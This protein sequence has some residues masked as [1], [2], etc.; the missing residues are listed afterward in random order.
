M[1]VLILSVLIKVAQVILLKY[2][3]NT[4]CSAFAQ[5][6]ALTPYFTMTYRELIQPSIPLFFPLGI[7]MSY[8]THI[9]SSCFKHTRIF[10]LCFRFRGFAWALPF[11]LKVLP[12]GVYM[13]SSSLPSNSSSSATFV[14]GPKLITL[15]R[16]YLSFC[17]T[18]IFSYFSVSHRPGDVPSHH[19]VNLFIIYS[20]LSLCPTR[21]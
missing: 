11:V 15:L 7:P 18:L 6:L 4:L 19:I 2:L 8:H 13:V 5:N 21:W 3:P 12:S 20:R 14:H 17:N 16:C 1:S 10:H 9:C